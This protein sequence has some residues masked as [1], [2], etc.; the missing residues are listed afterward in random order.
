VLVG[1]V[2]GSIGVYLLSV[3]RDPSQPAQALRA[4]PI[5]APPSPTDP[6][7]TAST[8]AAAPGT[9]CAAITTLRALDATTFLS[10]GMDTRIVVWSCP[11][12][13]PHH[14]SAESLSAAPP[15]TLHAKHVLTGHLF[16][17]YDLAV[18]RDTKAGLTTL[19]SVSTCEVL[20]TSFSYNKTPASI[21]SLL[22]L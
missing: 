18:A 10:A 12:P 19:W 21:A 22:Q 13:P 8:T 15:P 9:A 2:S 16:P 17:V 4:A 20:Q 5:A 7:L 3:L 14:T 11:A 6:S 1:G